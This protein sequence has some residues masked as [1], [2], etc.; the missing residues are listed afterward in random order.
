MEDMKKLLDK[1]IVEN[2]IIQIDDGWTSSFVI[3]KY[4][5]GID[6]WGSLSG[7]DRMI[8]ASRVNRI[9]RDNNLFLFQS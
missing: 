2:I 6:V 4:I 5:I 9:A 3:A 8:L 1:I 7:E